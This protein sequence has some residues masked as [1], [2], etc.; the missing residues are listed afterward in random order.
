MSQA[1]RDL[2]KAINPSFTQA[3][4][5]SKKRKAKDDDDAET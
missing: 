3:S 5:P 2:L 4:K 1:K